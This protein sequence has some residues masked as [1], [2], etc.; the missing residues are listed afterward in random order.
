M[1]VVPPPAA[2]GPLFVP[3]IDTRQLEAFVTNTN[4]CLAVHTEELR[5]HH[6]RLVHV[7]DECVFL[8]QE[9]KFH[10]AEIASLFKKHEDFVTVEEFQKSIH[11]LETK[12]DQL[13]DTQSFLM[14]QAMTQLESRFSS[15]LTESIFGL[16]DD[17]LKKMKEQISES[18]CIPKLDANELPLERMHEIAQEVE[19]FRDQ[20]KRLTVSQLCNMQ[21]FCNEMAYLCA[22][23][24]ADHHESI[25]QLTQSVKEIQKENINR[26]PT[27]GVG[28]GSASAMFGAGSGARS[29][30]NRVVPTIP[31]LSNIKETDSGS[32]STET[33]G[34]SDFTDETE[35]KRSP[36]FG[37]G[38]NSVQKQERDAHQQQVLA[39]QIPP[40]TE[41]AAELNVESTAEAQTQVANT[42]SDNQ[43]VV[44]VVADSA[45]GSTADVAVNGPFIDLTVSSE[46][47]IVR[48]ALESIP[49][50]DEPANTPGGNRRIRKQNSKRSSTSSLL[51]Q[52][53]IESTSSSNLNYVAELSDQMHTIQGVMLAQ[54]KQISDLTTALQGIYALMLD[55]ENKSKLIEKEELKQ[56][57]QNTE[58]KLRNEMDAN[59]QRVSDNTVQKYLENLNTSNAEWKEDATGMIHR[60]SEELASMKQSASRVPQFQISE[61]IEKVE[62]LEDEVQLKADKEQL[63]DKAERK[64]F[65]PIQNMLKQMKT[66][67]H[68]ADYATPRAKLDA[69]LNRSGSST[70][71]TVR[72]LRNGELPSSR[73]A[74]VVNSPKI[75][76][77]PSMESDGIAYISCMCCNQ[78][79][80]IGI[81]PADSKL[82]SSK[83][84]KRKT[85]T[86]PADKPPVTSSIQEFSASESEVEKGEHEHRVKSQQ[87]RLQVE[88]YSPQHLF[89][90]PLEP[91]HKSTSESL[92]PAH[93]SSID[94][95]T[96]FILNPASMARSQSVM[97]LKLPALDTPPQVSPVRTKKPMLR[98]EINARLKSTSPL[99]FLEPLEHKEYWKYAFKGSNQPS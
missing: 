94:S 32:G 4:N 90:S 2:S 75:H 80:P 26:R 59:Q 81:M 13:A 91:L 11:S 31:L 56:I 61:Y 79:I 72:S 85:A 55:H 57:L 74:S 58:V 28:T 71:Q 46:E 21:R 6:M 92:L 88:G 12:I 23:A 53:N 68:D 40:K 34:R 41:P 33:S 60:L 35:L 7:E 62:G 24:F 87:A 93:I 22:Y 73:A 17:L 38:E 49:E 9:S 65:T 84:R 48:Y 70:P 19:I 66:I 25:Q 43:S 20:S 10:S 63:K 37:V 47:G 3:L 44:S 8:R 82:G 86:A 30:V 14:N 76:V 77:H 15:A 42:T 83:P 16:R 36:T 18:V 5:E 39:N 78:A 1:E 27:F 97:E 45:A 95:A 89:A 64:D 96:S 50:V 98:A 67:L 52:Q 69:I 99:T 51:S 29:P 54:E